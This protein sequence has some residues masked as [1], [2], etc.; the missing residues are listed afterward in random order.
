VARMGGDALR[1]PDQH[2]V[3]RP[4]KYTPDDG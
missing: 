2:D 1:A 4:R 3:V